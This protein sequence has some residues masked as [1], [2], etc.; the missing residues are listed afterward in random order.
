MRIV[1]AICLACGVAIGCG[2]RDAAPAVAS[3][4][5]PKPKAPIVEPVQ[6]PAPPV[7]QPE[8]TPEPPK[9]KVETKWTETVTLIRATNEGKFFLDPIKDVKAYWRKDNA[10]VAQIALRTEDTFGL[11][12]GFGSKIIQADGTEWRVSKAVIGSIVPPHELHCYVT[13]VPKT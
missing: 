5:E 10:G 9:P 11:E 2:K 6:P 7:K 13:K 4:P 3:N 8:P 12:P 1:V